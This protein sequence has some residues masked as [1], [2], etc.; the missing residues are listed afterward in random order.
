MKIKMSKEKAFECLYEPLE[1]VTKDDPN[2]QE[3]LKNTIRTLYTF[4]GICSYYRDR[5]KYLLELDIDDERK[6]DIRGMLCDFDWCEKAIEKGEIDGALRHAFLA[7]KAVVAIDTLPLAKKGYD[8]QGGRRAGGGK[9]KK[10]PYVMDIIRQAAEAQEAQGYK[11]TPSIIEAYL[12]ENSPIIIDNDHLGYKEIECKPDSGTGQW[13]F[14][15]PQI[16]RKGI[17]TDQKKLIKFS[18]IKRYL[19]K[20]KE[21]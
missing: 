6:D 15:I 2:Y 11:V 9:E 10:D 5:A 1:K 7:G 18:A 3:R 16:N 19:R 8:A 14:E 20:I 4:K 12:K 17:E 21:S 13:Y